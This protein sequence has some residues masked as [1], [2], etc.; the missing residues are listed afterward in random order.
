VQGAPKPF[1]TRGE[2]LSSV[3]GREAEGG[4]AP[5]PSFLSVRK[6][7]RGLSTFVLLFSSVLRIRGRSP[8]GLMPMCLSVS[9]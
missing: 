6:D 4:R 2:P 3:T 5:P 1:H 7:F 9:P 8:L